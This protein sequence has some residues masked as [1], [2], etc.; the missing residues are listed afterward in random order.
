[1]GVVLS[2]IFEIKIFCKICKVDILQSERL[3]HLAEH[4]RKKEAWSQPCK[5]KGSPYV[6]G[7]CI[8]KEHYDACQSSN[9]LN[10]N[11]M[12]WRDGV[13]FTHVTLKIKK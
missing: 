7:V 4:I 2:E 3:V 5:L 10:N 1:M 6:V 13:L 8:S 11:W 9:P 12:C